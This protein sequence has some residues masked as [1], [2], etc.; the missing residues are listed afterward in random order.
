MIEQTAKLAR[1]LEQSLNAIGCSMMNND[2]AAKLLAYVYVCGGSN[3]N[4]THHEGIVAGINIAQRKFNLHGGEIPKAEG[5]ILIKEY[6]RELETAIEN[7]EK[8]EW[9]DE[10]EKRYN[11]ILRVK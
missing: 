2:F 9:I 5:V 4:I 7:E 3:E 11:L 1:D 10:I 6:V 8:C